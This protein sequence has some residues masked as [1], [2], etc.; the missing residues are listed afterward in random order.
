MPSWREACPKTIL[1][2]RSTSSK[3]RS[4]KRP[5]TGAVGAGVGVVGVVGAG[6]VATT[7]GG[8]IETALSDDDPPP[9]PPSKSAMHKVEGKNLCL[10][11]IYLLYTD[12]GVAEPNM[13]FKLRGSA[14][15]YG[16][17]LWLMIS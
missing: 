1:D 6:G 5:L 10:K 8:V 9:H 17:R 11:T 12:F 4:V 2:V 14:W 16:P 15:V 7:G 13:Q 3:I